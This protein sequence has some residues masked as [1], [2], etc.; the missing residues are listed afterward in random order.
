MK[1]L[2]ILILDDQIE[3][4]QI[5]QSMLVGSGIQCVTCTKISE[6]WNLLQSQNFSLFVTDLLVGDKNASDLIKK[7]RSDGNN[8]TIP[9]IAITADRSYSQKIS[10]LE[11]GVN[12]YLVK[13]VNKQELIVSIK[14]MI[15]RSFGH[16]S[17][18]VSNGDLALKTLSRQ[19]FVKGKLVQLT[20]KEY[21]TVVSLMFRCDE[22]VP[23]E[24]LLADIY[25][26]RVE[27][28]AGSE[29]KKKMTDVLI[30][31]IRHKIADA[32]ELPR[33]SPQANYIETLWGVG[34]R[35]VPKPQCSII[36]V[37]AAADNTAKEAYAERFRNDYSAE[38]E[39]DDNV[40]IMNK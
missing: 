29:K 26:D 30:C 7:I 21:D 28:A 5:L 1:I 13:P 31:K 11:S 15:A 3:Q 37:A 16:A 38:S 36:E 34:Y 12:Y 20:R 9:I 23:K 18:L 39:D 4:L 6:A 35:L 17:N 10:S 14:N 32:C 8:R 2:N 24:T 19:F 22:F 25:G 27:A 40:L 33:N